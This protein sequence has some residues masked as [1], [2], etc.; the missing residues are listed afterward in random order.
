MKDIVL[1]TRHRQ[2]RARGG[3]GGLAILKR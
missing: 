3:A 2:T 1:Q